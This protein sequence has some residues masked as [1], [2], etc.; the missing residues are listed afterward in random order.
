MCALLSQKRK[1][2]AKVLLQAQE[3]LRLMKNRQTS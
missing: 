3:L 1:M 2:M